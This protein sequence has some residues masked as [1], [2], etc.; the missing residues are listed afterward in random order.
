[1]RKDANSTYLSTKLK[2]TSW[3]GQ[4]SNQYW[5]FTNLWYDLRFRAYNFLQFL[6]TQM[7]YKRFISFLISIFCFNSGWK[8]KEL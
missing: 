5:P 4:S 8:T 2:F 6:P 3:P 7:L 1:M